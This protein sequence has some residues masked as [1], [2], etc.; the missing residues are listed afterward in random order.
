MNNSPSLLILFATLFAHFTRDFVCSCYS[1]LSVKMIMYLP[2]S[3]IFFAMNMKI[4]M[5][6][7]SI[8][9]EGVNVMH[10]QVFGL[11]ESMVPHVVRK[12]IILY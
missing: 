12:T 1:L 6:A 3:L 7:K 4:N 10:K 5:H 11:T 2:I 8:R 9:T